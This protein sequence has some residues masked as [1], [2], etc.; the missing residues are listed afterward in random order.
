MPYCRT[1]SKLFL[2]NPALIYQT[3]QFTT[4]RVILAVPLSTRGTSQASCLLPLRGPQMPCSLIQS[5]R[6]STSI[7]DLRPHPAT[8]RAI[9]LAPVLA[10]PSPTHPSHTPTAAAWQASTSSVEA[11]FMAPT[12]RGWIA[13]STLPRV[14]L[15]SSILMPVPECHGGRGVVHCLS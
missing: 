7:S 12:T 15:M 1:A 11:N 2:S 9:K 13:A 4:L 3:G 10:P 5:L 14:C 8:C 6:R